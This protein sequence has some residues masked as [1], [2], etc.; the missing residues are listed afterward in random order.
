[1]IYFKEWLNHPSVIFPPVV[2]SCD[3]DHEAFIC[4]NPITDFKQ[5]SMVPTIIGYTTG[6]GGLVVSGKLN[7]QF[8]N[9]IVVLK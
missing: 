3:S 2:E 4:R 1:M 7:C 6:E 8:K 9:K 5:E